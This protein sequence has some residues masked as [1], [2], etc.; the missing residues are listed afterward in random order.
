MRKAFTI[1]S[2][3]HCSAHKNGMINFLFHLIT[4]YIIPGM[5][6]GFTLC[7]FFQ[8]VP[9]REKLKEYTLARRF[10]LE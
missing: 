10:P 1:Q 7:F 9:F 8:T 2:R 3:K 6:L 5:L 4:A